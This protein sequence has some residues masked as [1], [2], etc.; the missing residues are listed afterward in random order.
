M[1]DAMQKGIVAMKFHAKILDPV[2]SQKVIERLSSLGMRAPCRVTVVSNKGS[3]TLSGAIQ[4]EHQR[5]MAL[6]AASTVTGVQRVVD[7]MRTIPNG[8]HWKSTLG[9]SV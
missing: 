3:V 9:G 6:R 8:Q 7:Q 5:R 1:S 4:Y 2:L